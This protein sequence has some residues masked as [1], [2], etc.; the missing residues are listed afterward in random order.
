MRR[1]GPDA[2]APEGR[3]EAGRLESLNRKALGWP[4]YYFNHML[5]DEEFKSAG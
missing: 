2:R 4:D 5:F 1:A 3:A